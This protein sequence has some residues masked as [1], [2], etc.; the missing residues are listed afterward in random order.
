MQQGREEFGLLLA[1]AGRLVQDLKYDV[2]SEKHGPHEIVLD[3]TLTTTTRWAPNTPLP[4][5]MRTHLLLEPPPQPGGRERLFRLFEEWNGNRQLNEKTT[6][7]SALGRVH[8]RLRRF[9]G[10]M[11]AS[12]VRAGYM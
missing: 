11:A 1:S 5:R 9:T 3:W 7:P 8:Q 2:H 12:A 4:L 10:Y 6:W